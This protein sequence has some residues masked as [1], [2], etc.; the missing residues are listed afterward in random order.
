[1]ETSEKDSAASLGHKGNN[2]IACEDEREQERQERTV[3]SRGYQLEMFEKS[4]Q[5]NII[6][7]VIDTVMLVS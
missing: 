3:V 5:H 4:M 1:M 2:K 6:V 7:T